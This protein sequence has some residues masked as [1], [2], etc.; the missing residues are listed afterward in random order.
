[1]AALV[2]G[3][4][5][6]ELMAEAIGGLK[7]GSQPRQGSLRAGERATLQTDE[8]KGNPARAQAVAEGLAAIADDL[9]PLLVYAWRRHLSAAIVR[10]VSESETAWTK[11]VR[12]ADP[13]GCRGMMGDD[14]AGHD[15]DDGEL[16]GDVG[17]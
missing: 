11:G 16:R 12:S 7:G 17:R 15:G 13:A 2:R 1:V 9:E 4:L 3:G 10:M 14:A 8:G 6:D 5:V